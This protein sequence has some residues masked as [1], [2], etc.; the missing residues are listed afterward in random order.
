[1]KGSAE[2]YKAFQ[3]RVACLPSPLAPLPASGEGNRALPSPLDGRRVGD[4]GVAYV[5]PHPWPLSR[6][7]ARARGSGC[8]L[9]RWV[10]EGMGLRGD[11]R[12]KVSSGGVQ[13]L[14]CEKQTK[15]DI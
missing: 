2:E 10:G 5:C 6:S 7:F 13:D 14:P 9:L 15:V 12:R 4:E 1:L 8:F 3:K 11:V